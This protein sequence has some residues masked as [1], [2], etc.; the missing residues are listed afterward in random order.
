MSAFGGIRLNKVA[1]VAVL[2][3]GTAPATTDEM[4]GGTLF[5]ALLLRWAN[6]EGEK[7]RCCPRLRSVLNTAPPAE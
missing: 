6:V 4:T 3:R 2:F 5:S 1:V 7:V